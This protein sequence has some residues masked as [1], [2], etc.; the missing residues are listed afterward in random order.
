VANLTILSRKQVAKHN[1]ET[2]KVA[3]LRPTTE[4][5]D[6]PGKRGGG[7]IEKGALDDIG[8]ISSRE[9]KNRRHDPRKPVKSN[10][11]LQGSRRVTDEKPRRKGIRHPVK[12]GYE[13]GWTWRGDYRIS[14]ASG[15]PG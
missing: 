14:R 1:T 9:I 11:H 8:C 12:P 2:L 6:P 13:V 4:V 5:R 10:K 7:P 15:V 3:E